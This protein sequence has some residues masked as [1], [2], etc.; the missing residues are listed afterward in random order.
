MTPVQVSSDNW[1]AAFFYLCPVR[2]QMFTDD[3]RWQKV[4]VMLWVWDLV[5]TNHTA[6]ARAAAHVP[7]MRSLRLT[8]CISLVMIVTWYRTSLHCELSDSVCDHDKRNVRSWCF[9]M[10]MWYALV[11]VL[12]DNGNLPTPYHVL[13]DAWP[14]IF[15]E[16]IINKLY[17]YRGPC[18]T[19][20]WTCLMVWDE[21]N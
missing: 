8:R 19:C 13:L 14:W 7:H 6:S 15:I 18:F 1:D 4:S 20:K 21:D 12:S 11:N 2:T 9:K 3:R 10:C 5:L 17:Y 16:L